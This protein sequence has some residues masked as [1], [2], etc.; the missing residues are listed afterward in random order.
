[1][2]GYL[3]DLLG[4]DVRVGAT[5]VFEISSEF[6]TSCV[7]WIISEMSVSFADNSFSSDK[8][9]SSSGIALG[10]TSICSFEI[11]DIFRF[12]VSVSV[13]V[14]VRK[15]GCSSGRWSDPI[16]SSSIWD[17][18]SEPAIGIGWETSLLCSSSWLLSTTSSASI[19]GSEAKTDSSSLSSGWSSEVTL[20]N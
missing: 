2:F 6:S 14:S 17:S 7:G 16:G 3:N 10:A 5:G 4:I 1:M 8:G 13:S 12:S 9:E 11:C 18:V 20:L 19:T 15:T